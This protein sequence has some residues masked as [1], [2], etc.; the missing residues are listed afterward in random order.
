LEVYAATSRGAY[1]YLPA[2]HRAET[3]LQEDVREALWTAG[4]SQQSLALAPA[5][6]V[7]SAVFE[8]TAQRYGE[9]AERYVK[10]EAG[11]AAENLLLQ[12]VALGLGA[13]VIGAFY[14]QDVA[15]AL[16]LPGEEEPLYLIPV[17]HPTE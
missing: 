2:D 5:I 8:R 10:L 14:D 12:A 11:H 1:H 9:R 13:V 6:F 15:T 16:N 4:L 17:G 3:T 7:V